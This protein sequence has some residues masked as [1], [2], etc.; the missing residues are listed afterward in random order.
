MV[1]KQFWKYFGESLLLKRNVIEDIFYFLQA[2][3]KKRTKCPY[4]GN[5]YS[6]Y[7]KKFAVIDIC[8]CEK[9]G[10]F[11]V[12][13]IYFASNIQFFY[14]NFYSSDVTIMPS[15]KELEVMMSRYFRGTNKDFNDRLLVIRKLTAG[16]QLLE[17][18]SSWGYFLFQAQSHGFVCKGVEISEK[19]ASFGRKYL[20]VNI[21]NDL[22]LVPGK[23]DIVYSAHTLEHLTNI[24]EIFDKFC[25]K[26]FPDGILLIEVP[27]FDPE[28]KGKSVYPT[29]GKVH[30]LGFCKEFFEQNLRNHGFSA[31][32]IAG[33]YE[34]LLKRKEERP[35]LNNVVI[36]QATRKP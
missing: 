22:D 30:A 31:I 7:D 10:L 14:N 5:G 35:P 12:N 28:T 13:P 27:N 18:G 36:V 32:N 8:K 24:S 34:D 33:N 26:L 16:K 6:I 29:I 19:R 17:F 4:C 3:T 21:F 20:G 9:C 2:L 15:K 11:F 1:I 23:F 25:E